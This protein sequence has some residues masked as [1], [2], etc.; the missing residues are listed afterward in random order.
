MGRFV[1]AEDYVR[2]MAG[3]DRL[4]RD[5]DTALDSIEALIL[6][7]LPIPAPPIGAGTVTVGGGRSRSEV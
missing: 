6:P 3:R 5:V 2:A 4:R 1:L 7:T